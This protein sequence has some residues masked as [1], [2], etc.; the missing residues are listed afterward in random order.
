MAGCDG[1]APRASGGILAADAATLP[2]DDPA[3]P[4]P[5]PVA[6]ERIEV[7]PPDGRLEVVL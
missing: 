6:V 1:A 7:S 5:L 3:G 4:G 2:S